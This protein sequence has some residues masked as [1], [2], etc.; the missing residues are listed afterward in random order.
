LPTLTVIENEHV[1]LY[2]HTDSKIVHHIYQPTIHGEFIREQLN[3]GVNLLKEHEANKWLSDNSRFNDLSPEDS[4]WINSVWLP[5][6][7]EAGWQFWAL[8]VPEEDAARMN[9]VQFVTNF[10]NMGVQTRIF[11]DP[12]AAMAWL[13]SVE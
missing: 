8:V 2:Y 4:E 5:N 9:M 6:A 12:D 1:V 3:Q 7:I 10:A 11:T 13:V